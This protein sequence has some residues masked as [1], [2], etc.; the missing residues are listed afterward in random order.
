MGASL[1][2]QSPGA[3]GI[4]AGIVSAAKA[5]NKPASHVIAT[6]KHCPDNTAGAIV[7]YLCARTEA[8]FSAQQ[9]PA[10]ATSVRLIVMCGSRGEAGSCAT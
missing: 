5:S 10:R 4:R 2:T 9:Q 1:C 8:R 7:K 3:A 6:S